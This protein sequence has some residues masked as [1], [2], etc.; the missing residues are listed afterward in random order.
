MMD[1]EKH[2]LYTITFDDCWSVDIS[3]TYLSPFDDPEEILTDVK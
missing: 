3:E 2:N 1:S